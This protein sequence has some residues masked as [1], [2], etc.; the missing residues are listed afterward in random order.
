MQ[1]K[2]GH[3]N[4]TKRF[5]SV[6]TRKLQAMTPVEDLEH[7]TVGFYGADTPFTFPIPANIEIK[8]IADAVNASMYQWFQIG[9][10][11][12]HLLNHFR[13]KGCTNNARIK[14]FGWSWGSIAAIK[15]S[16]SLGR[17]ELRNHEIDV[18]AIDPVSTLRFPSAK[19][20]SNV[21]YFW[22]RYETHGGPV[23]GP[24][25]LHGRQLTSNAK[26]TEQKDLNPGPKDNGINHVQIVFEV[27]EELIRKLRQ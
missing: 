26:S 3:Q 21:T 17:S 27:A 7:I 5:C 1:G 18:F 2:C 15:L 9:E 20:P 14:I 12:R 6:Q 4:A 19:V 10:A 24:L 8:R 11:Y 23:L 16:R 13:H 22:N 25:R